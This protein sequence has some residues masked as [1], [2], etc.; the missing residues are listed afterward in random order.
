[1]KKFSS[2]L[3]LFLLWLPASWAQ[4]YLTGYVQNAGNPG[5]IN[6]ESDAPGQ[7]TWT[8]LLPASQSANQWS[9]ATAIPF[10][11]DFFGQPVT[12]FKASLNGVVT[13]DT[14]T[15][16][17][18]GANENLPSPN[19]PNLSIAGFWDEF[20]SSAPTGGNDEVRINTFGT[21]PNRQFW[22]KWYSFEIGNPNVSF[23][24]IAIVLEEGTNSVYVVDQYSSSS[25]LL[26]A[27]VG[28]QLDG[29]T[30][31]QIG[32]DQTAQAGNGSNLLDNDYYIFS[33]LSGAALDVTPISVSSSAL[34]DA[35]CGG[36][37]EPV[38]IQVRSLG[39]SATSGIAATF[40]VDNGTPVTPE[41]IPGVLNLGD[42]VTYTFT[43]TADLSTPGPH[44]ITVVASVIGDGDNTND[45]LSAVFT[46]IAA[47]AP[48]LPVVDFTGFTGSNLTALFPDWSEGS[49]QGAPSGTTSGWTS[50]DFG[51][52]SGGPNGI[53]AKINLYNTGDFGWIVGPKISPTAN[54]V[55]EWDIAITNWNGTNA[56]NLGSDDSVAL[57]I[58][59]DCGVTFT[60]VVVY[61][62]TSNV[63]PAGQ[64][65]QFS[66]ASYVGQD[67][68]VAFYATEGAIDDPE[69]NDI[70]LDNINIKN[71]SP[72]DMGVAS[73]VSPTGTSCFGATETVTVEIQNYGTATIDFSVDNTTI[74]LSVT[75]A[76]TGTYNTTL[77]SGTLTPGATMM[78]DVSTSVDLSQLGVNSLT[79]YTT[80][81]GD[82]NALNDTAATTA[83]TGQTFAL[84]YLEDFETFTVGNPGT[85]ANGWTTLNSTSSF[86]WHVEQDGTTNSS[87]TGP[88]DDHTTGGQVYMFTETSSGSLGDEYFLFSPCID[89][90][91][92]TTPQLSFWYHM[93]GGDMGTLEAWVFR[94]GVDSTVVFSLSGE[95]QTSENDPWLQAIVDLTAY[96]GETVQIVFRGVRGPGFESDM[97]IDDVEIFQPLPADAGTVGLLSPIASPGCTGAAETVIVQVR[98]FGTS[99]IDFTTDPVQVTADITGPIA[100]NFATTVN[101]GTLNPGDTLDV[102]VTTAAD[103]S[104]TGTYTFTL[105]T[106]LNGDGNTTNDTTV[107]AVTP[108]ASESVPYLETFE[109]GFPTTWEND[110]NDSGEDWRYSN[111]TNT[112]YGPDAVDHTT[113]SGEYMWVDDSSPHNNP[114][115]LITPCFDLSGL[116][117]PIMEFW[118]WSQIEDAN[119]DML[120]HLD[121]EVDGVWNDDII[122]PLA[123][124]GAAWNL[125]SQS[126]VPYIGSTVRVRFRAEEVG[127]GFQHDVAID[128]FRIFDQQNDDLEMV[129]IDA[130]G[131]GGR[132]ATSSALT[133]TQAVT[134]KV[135]NAGLLAAS[136][137]DLS[138]VINA[139]TPVTETIAGPLAAGDTL[140]YTFTATA[141]LSAAGIYDLEVY[142][143]YGPD[144]VSANDTLAT[145]IKHLANPAITLPY[146][147][148]FESTPD[149]AY[150]GGVFGVD[151]ADRVDFESADISGRLRTA[152][153]AGYYKTGNR[154]VT[155]DRDPSGSNVVNY[156]FLT[157]NMTNYTTNDSILL[158]FSVQNNGEETHPNDRVWVRGS[159]IDSWIEIVDLNAED[160]APGNYA[161]IVDINISFILDTAGQSYS[162]S[163]QL[164]F[165]QEDN[166][167]STS[168]SVSDG[169]TFDDIELTILEAN[170]AQSLAIMGLATGACGDSMTMGMLVVGNNGYLPQTGLNA[171]VIATSGAGADTFNLT[172]SNTLNF[173]QADTLMFG[174]VNTYA[175]GV[176]DFVAFTTLAGDSETANDSVSLT[177]EFIPSEVLADSAEFCVGDSATVS[178]TN[179]SG[180]AD[181]LWYADAMGMNQIATG[182]SYETGALAASDTFYVGYADSPDSLT[183]F[184]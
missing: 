47:Q 98:N 124:Q 129:S 173:N 116:S 119:Q 9:A 153:G 79:A 140:T 93:F 83:E 49:G 42:T 132:E 4:S 108:G 118:I 105:F 107:V 184:F 104:A 84:P 113:G 144:G 127:T 128:D 161:D 126:L 111:P 15:T 56:V 151:G 130:P 26:T 133:A 156:M 3:C 142:S 165:G 158:S 44:T 53:S 38:T 64:T 146:F 180:L 57:M 58:S 102:T 94:P 121:L 106:D 77:T 95:Q 6:T 46:T 1:M 170:D 149:T 91:G 65:D 178:V 164:R 138:Y 70:F 148:G 174:P 39:T 141:D 72:V 23:A 179:A 85:T 123:S 27:T 43:A 31:V 175:G 62:A 159:D 19:F 41:I 63:N 25:P 92:S 29:S 8:T 131:A 36:A 134:V 152:A 136:N 28:L 18:P 90:S 17:L 122:A 2:F 120:L 89:L 33:P 50:D 12:H 100:Q 10:A 7:G 71:L 177:V 169:Y 135:R 182:T 99:A 168:P 16:I 68:I 78:V 48:P 88:L 69:D 109:N 11:F 112:T 80:V 34:V 20:T 66:L 76:N 52:V 101:T 67:V 97:A 59:T 154:A 73:I 87:G 145:S 32:N 172:S 162:S 171:T 139:G 137:F 155:L 125:I 61:D 167:P 5:G 24:Y 114:I 176:F 143:T 166:F 117:N 30:A 60:P 35:G 115:N 147:E 150:F 96:A 157:L 51:N 183:T 14:A 21:A 110:A 75:G 160:A 103:L 74:D 37:A 13:F 22:I 82:G 163:T 86:G 81:A 54:S 40:V 55:V 181:Y 45:T